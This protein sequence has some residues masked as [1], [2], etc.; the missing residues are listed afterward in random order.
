MTF[1]AQ[2]G[3]LIPTPTGNNVAL[4]DTEFRLLVSYIIVF[5]VVVLVTAAFSAVNERELRRRRYDLEALAKFSLHLETV[6]KGTDVAEI[7]C[8]RV[9]DEFGFQRVL[10]FGAR[11]G[12]I[13]LM[14]ALGAA[15]VSEDAPRPGEG[16]FLARIAASHETLLVSKFDAEEDPGLAAL[17]P[18]CQNLVMAP[19]NAEGRPVGLLICEHGM[20]SGSR[21]ERRVVSMLE[22]LRARSRP[23]RCRTPGCWRCSGATPRPTA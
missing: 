19:L 13:F 5:W 20:R 1:H 23:W 10:M 11:E 2:E 8:E 3:G 17:M 16:Q 4:G 18:G 12:D 9:A 15:D 14:H 6:T 7:L 22:R 21:I